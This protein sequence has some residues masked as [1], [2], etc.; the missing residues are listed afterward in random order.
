M[1]ARYGYGYTRR[2]AGASIFDGGGSTH[3][4][5]HAHL[6]SDLSASTGRRSCAAAQKMAQRTPAALDRTLVGDAAAAAAAAADDDGHPP[7]KLLGGSAATSPHAPAA[8]GACALADGKQTLGEKALGALG[9][10]SCAVSPILPRGGAGPAVAPSPPTSTLLGAGA[11]E[12]R[13]G[14][15]A[16]PPRT[17][18]PELRQRL[19]R[20][21]RPNRRADHHQNRKQRLRFPY[22]TT[23]CSFG[24]YPDSKTPDTTAQGLVRRPSHILGGRAVC[25]VGAAGQALW[26]RAA[27]GGRAGGLLMIPGPRSTDITLHSQA[28][29]LR[30]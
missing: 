8:A 1:R 27:P 7:T 10:L 23:H 20:P 28:L 29:S 16:E 30:F 14:P 19:V 3:H 13:R 26:G 21:P 4:S 9:A 24:S 15:L 18:T 12:A 2:G 11:L 5:P 25:A 17:S 22:V 6:K